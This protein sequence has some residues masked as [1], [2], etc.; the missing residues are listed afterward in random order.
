MVLKLQ[1]TMLLLSCCWCDC[2][3]WCCCLCTLSMLSSFLIIILKSLLVIHLDFPNLNW[4]SRRRHHGTSRG[5][6][7]FHFKVPRTSPGR[8]FTT[9]P[10]SKGTSWRRGWIGG[11]VVE[12][13][14]TGEILILWLCSFKFFI[15]TIFLCKIIYLLWTISRSSNFDSASPQSPILHCRRDVFSVVQS[16]VKFDTVNKSGSP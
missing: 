7:A 14:I 6:K 16:C 10:R 2:C 12:P 1:K 4:T 11:K 8:L 9:S 5:R 15:S 13:I 3:C